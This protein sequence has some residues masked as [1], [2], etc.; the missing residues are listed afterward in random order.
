VVLIAA[1]AGRTVCLALDEPPRI[2]EREIGAMILDALAA[3]GCAPRLVTVGDPTIMDCDVF[4]LVGDA[5]SLEPHLPV[6]RQRGDRRP[7]T[8]LWQIHPLLPPTAGDRAKQASRWLV[9]VDRPHS[10][11]R[12]IPQD[13][14][15][16][17]RV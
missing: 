1:V 15:V 9:E 8:I 10:G 2:I 7:R 6:L 13:G 3:V 12:E 14:P 4:L 16:R 17:R 11:P 5:M